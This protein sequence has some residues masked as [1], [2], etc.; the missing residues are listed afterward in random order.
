MIPPA[1][2]SPAPA[3]RLPPPLLPPKPP[4]R[5]R[6]APSPQWSPL[7]PLQLPAPLGAHQELL[8]PAP[9]AVPEDGPSRRELLLPLVL[10]LSALLLLF[11]G[12][13]QLDLP[14]AAAAD[15]GGGP[16]T[17]ASVEPAPGAV[18]APAE[19]RV[20]FSAPMDASLLLSDVDRSETIVLVPRDQAEVMF[21]ALG[22]SRLTSR[23]R[24]LLVPSRSA[25]DDDASSLSLTPDAPLATG[26]YALLVSPRLRGADGHSKVSGP[27][28]FLYQVR[29]L[30]PRPALVGPLAGSAAPRNLH[31]VRLD[32]PEA[33]PGALLALGSQDRL[34]AAAVAPSEAGPAAIDLCPG[35][36][37]AQLSSGSSYTVS[38]DGQPIEG[39]S[40]T[41]ADCVRAEPPITRSVL[42]SA[43]VAAARLAIELDWPA[44]ITVEW[45]PAPSVAPTTD[46][47]SALEHLCRGGG[48]ARATAAA[49]CAPSSCEPVALDA[50]C[51]AHLELGKLSGSST[52]LWRATIA[53][54][55]GHV[56][57]L[58]AARF[59]TLALLPAVTID[60][61]MASPPAPAPRAEGEYIE[62]VNSGAGAV[63]A[64]RLALVGPD[65][66]VR[67][68]IA[69][70]PAVPLLLQPGQRALAV[71]A[72]F[73]P[74]RYPLPAGTV[75][76]HAGT[77]RLLG[78]GLLHDGSQAFALVLL[79][80]A[81]S[82][83]VVAPPLELSRFPGEGPA[84]PAGASLE[85][86]YPP[87]KPG[88]PLFRC[89]A[90][91]GS[92]GRAP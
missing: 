26:D 45:A 86:I 59:S 23:E 24:G 89:G 9:G 32:L 27:L 77:R 87:P 34:V 91:G 36:H 15:G 22:H 85:R 52:W 75:L 78:R 19:L 14:N 76:L 40:F 47:E 69:A 48:C 44:Q 1:S 4:G 12:C 7:W 92:P 71:G 58:P 88:A 17:V 80:A 57:T 28:R 74:N 41:V 30:P 50:P 33:R 25:I 49:L 53:D 2:Q 51:S 5:S 84:C 16:P 72:S 39:A 11:T 67:P 21:A 73:D 42:L 55:E 10:S 63:E 83:T 35:G 38:L 20:R 13:A 61:V 3:L 79:P 65:G 82:A 46:D 56:R 90:L 18:T 62:V 37:C 70:P 54:D 43:K 66:L 64:A 60:E 29:A 8:V 81:G 6:S 31:Q 68:L